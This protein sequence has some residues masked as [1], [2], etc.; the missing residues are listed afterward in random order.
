MLSALPSVS[1]SSDD[2]IGYWVPVVCHWYPHNLSYVLLFL[3]LGCA[4]VKYSSHAEAQAAINALHGSQTMPV[5]SP[6]T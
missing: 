6:I 2:R 1:T 3:F 5:S 4:F